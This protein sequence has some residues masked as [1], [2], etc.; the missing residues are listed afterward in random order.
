V[1]NRPKTTRRTK[2]RDL[3]AGVDVGGTKVAVV[4]CDTDTGDELARDSFSTPADATPEALLDRVSES[5]EA[6]G[7]IHETP[8]CARR[9][10]AGASRP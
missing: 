9:R 10:G 1:A 3:V 6:L 2:S 7:S 5:I 4:V 8:P